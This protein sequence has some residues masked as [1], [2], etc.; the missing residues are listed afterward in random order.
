MKEPVPPIPDQA[1]PVPALRFDF[2]AYRHYVEGEN[3]TEE[4]QRQLLDAVWRVVTGFVDLGF[5]IHPVQQALDVGKRRS[6]LAE[7][8]FAG[9]SCAKEFN[10]KSIGKAAHAASRAA[11]SGES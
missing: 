3:L 6:T 5:H 8:A 11:E 2:E 7:D 4:E 1:V 10:Q 9:L